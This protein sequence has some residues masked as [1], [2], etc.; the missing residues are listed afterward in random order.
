MLHCASC[1]PGFSLQLQVIQPT[2]LPRQQVS[3]LTFRLW[4]L[5]QVPR[6]CLLQIQPSETSPSFWN[7]LQRLLSK[8]PRV[9]LTRLT[10]DRGVSAADLEAYRRWESQPRHLAS[11][12]TFRGSEVHQEQKRPPALQPYHTTPHHDQTPPKTTAAAPRSD[13]ASPVSGSAVIHIHNSLSQGLPAP[14]HA[15]SSGSCIEDDALRLEATARNTARSRVQ[16]RWWQ[17]QCT[18]TGIASL[19]RTPG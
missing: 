17:W 15:L 10:M 9:Y 8:P 18:G 6:R 3:S 5:S 1:L 19:D 7:H 4:Q 16:L 13:S 12:S 2:N 14:N 11:S